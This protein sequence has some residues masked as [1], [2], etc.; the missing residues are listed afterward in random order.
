VVTGVDGSSEALTLA[1]RNAPDAQFLHA[2]ART[3]DLPREYDAVL[4]LFD[5]LNH[6]LTLPDLSAVFRNVRTALRDDG[7]FLFDL[8][9]E[10]KYRTTWTGS[11]AIVEDDLVGA[12][13]GGANF[14][15]KI[16]T[17]DAALFEKQASG[18]WRRADVHLRQTW[19]AE[20]EVLCALETAGFS[21]VTVHCP[22]GPDKLYFH[23][24][25]S[26][27]RE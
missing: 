27:S 19:Y 16:A 14:D 2:D 12:F 4:S 6:V 7:V 9:T 10:N 25:G 15:E 3:L 21:H 23:A 13:R 18:A 20:T 8:N 26:G 5:S 24:S 22:D 11:F 17:F 1:R